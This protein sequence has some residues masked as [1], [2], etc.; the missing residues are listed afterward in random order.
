MHRRHF[1]KGSAL[2]FGVAATPGVM[3]AATDEVVAV[4]QLLSDY[5]SVYY[6]DLDAPKYRALFTDDYL[7]LEDGEIIDTEKDV[8]GIP[9]P[10]SGYRRKDSFDFRSV[11]IHGDTAYLAYFLKSEIT[12]K[13]DGPRTREFLESMIVRR[14]NT[15]GWRTALLHST[16]VLKP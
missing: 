16:R 2:L 12:D 14:S 9:A 13:K 7:M 15:G 10:D 8:A 4:K 11:K 3:Q 5:Y 6:T 1:L